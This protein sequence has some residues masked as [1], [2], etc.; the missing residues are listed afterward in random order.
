MSQLHS[1]PQPAGSKNI[2]RH[3]IGH[4]RQAYKGPL[5]GL[6]ALLGYQL[7]DVPTAQ[8]TP[9][10]R[11]AGRTSEEQHQIC[12]SRHGQ[13]TMRIRVITGVPAQQCPSC[14]AHP[15]LH[16]GKKPDDM[17]E[18]INETRRF[19]FRGGEQPPCATTRPV[20][21]TTSKSKAAP[22]PGQN[23][24]ALPVCQLSNV[25]T[26]QRTQACRQEEHRTT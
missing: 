2:E 15:S 7:S 11:Q 18:Q 13:A 21:W 9:A 4:S 16:A 8:S 6:P 14:S 10:C 23:R 12:H 1:A 5:T 24:D 20:I 3:E 25:P 17:N 19:R 22:P 26:A